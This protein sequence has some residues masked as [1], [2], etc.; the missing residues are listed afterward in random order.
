MSEDP[1]QGGAQPVPTGRG[2]VGRWMDDVRYPVTREGLLAYAD[3]AA[4]PEQVRASLARLPAEREFHGSHELWA[5]L[6][7]AGERG[8]FG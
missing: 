2:A 6:D 4:A 7:Q 1:S 3:R 5:A 8:E